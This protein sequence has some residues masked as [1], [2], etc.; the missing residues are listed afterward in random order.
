LLIGRVTGDGR[1]SAAISL[2]LAALVIVVGV[3]VV[4]VRRHLHQRQIIASV[5]ARAEV[6]EPRDLRELVDRLEA[7]HGRLEMRRLRRLVR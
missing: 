4:Y 7:E 3:T 1:L 2:G 6:L 5:E